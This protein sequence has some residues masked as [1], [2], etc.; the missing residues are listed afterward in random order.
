MKPLADDGALSVLNEIHSLMM[1]SGCKKLKA[2]KGDISRI[3]L[4]HG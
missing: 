2:L 3:M 1:I 4:M